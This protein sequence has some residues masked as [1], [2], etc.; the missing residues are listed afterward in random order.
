MLKK[1]PDY[2]AIV[3]LWECLKQYDDVGYA[4]KVVEQNPEVT[5]NFQRDLFHNLMFNYIVLKGYLEDEEDR[6]ISAPSK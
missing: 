3:K 6:R 1:H 5:E 4:V 2:K